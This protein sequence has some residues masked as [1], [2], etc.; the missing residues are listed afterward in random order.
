MLVARI[1]TFNDIV[2]RISSSLDFVKTTDCL[3]KRLTLSPPESNKAV[4]L[5]KGVECVVV[6]QYINQVIKQLS[7]HNSV[8]FNSF[9]T[10]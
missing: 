6:M 7:V 8:L 2:F 4:I 1:F 9:S 5:E 10:D 3:A